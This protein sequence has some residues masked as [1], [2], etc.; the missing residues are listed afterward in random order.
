[1]TNRRKYEPIGTGLLPF[2][3]LEAEVFRRNDGPISRE[4]I[5]TV[6]GVSKRAVDRWAA[7]GISQ[8]RA[9][10]AAAALRLS[11]HDLWGGPDDDT[12]GT[13]VAIRE[14][15]A[16]FAEAPCRGLPGE[17]FYPPLSTSG[18]DYGDSPN[19]I[20]AKRVCNGSDGTDGGPALGECPVRDECLGY[21]LEHNEK[22]G[23]WGGMG[24]NT[25]R[26]L[27]RRWVAAR[28]ERVA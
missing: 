19:E 4:M 8:Y 1:M 23:V 22:H 5:G 7:V 12:P 11:K 25:R 9:G 20:P 28:N 16:F 21:A 2:A 6:L 17:L 15:P 10:E 3:P 24:E 27:R 18:K 26:K 14:R 13:P